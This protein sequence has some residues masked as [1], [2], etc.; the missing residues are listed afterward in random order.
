MK[1]LTLYQPYADAIA[2]S[3]KL[4]ENRTWA[5]PRSILG[6]RIAIHAGASKRNEHWGLPPGM[7]VDLAEP[8]P[9]SAIVCT[10][11]VLGALD[12]TNQRKPEVH[13]ALRV[14]ENVVSFRERM[15]TTMPKSP[16]WVGPVGWLLG[17]VRSLAEPVSCKGAMGLWT[18][19]ADIEQIVLER[20][21]YEVI[22]QK[23]DEAGAAY[24]T[25][26]TPRDE[27]L[28]SDSFG[29]PAEALEVA[30]E[31]VQRDLWADRYL[32]RSNMPLLRLA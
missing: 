6:E 29:D 27:R 25:V 26:K 8:L 12:L 30:R 23:I 3:G 16:W 5:P 10:A 24:W 11:V 2:W 15:L 13:M 14:K 22:G 7:E 28:V 4:V 20:T 19:P 21:K 9:R 31:Q 18:L 32:S 17:D 1:A